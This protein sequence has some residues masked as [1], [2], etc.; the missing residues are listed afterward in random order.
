MDIRDQ[1]SIGQKRKPATTGRQPGDPTPDQIAEACEAIRKGWSECETARRRGL[2]KS[3]G[4]RWEIP[5]VRESGAED[6][7]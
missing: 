4:D 6:D 5:T 7:E 2:R 1:R 3:D